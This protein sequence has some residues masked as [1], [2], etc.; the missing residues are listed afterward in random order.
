[1]ST[2]A[3]F[4][5]N[6][7]STFIEDTAVK[8]SAQKDFGTYLAKDAVREMGVGWD[9][10]NTFDAWDGQGLESETS[11]R[12]PKTTREMIAGVAERG[13]KTIRIPVTWHNHIIDNNYTIDPA[14]INRVKEVVDWALDS[15]L[16]VILN[17]HH[18]C[19]DKNE[20]ITYGQGYYP[21]D[22]NYEESARFVKNMWAQIAL[23][24]NGGY[25]HHLIFE[26]L[27]EPRLRGTPYEWN[28]NS[29]QPI[30]RQAADNTNKL[31]QLALDT[32]RA[33][34]GNNEKRFVMCPSLYA[35]VDTAVKSDFIMP[36]DTSEGRLILSTH[37]YSP[38]DFAMQSPGAEKFTG[39]HARY[40]ERM[41]DSLNANFVSRG[42]PVIMGE[43]GAVNKNNTEERIKWAKTYLNYA[44]K[45]NIPCCL[46]DNGDWK[47][48]GKTSPKRYEEKFGFYNRTENTW[49]F[50]ELMDAMIE[51]TE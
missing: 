16:Y 27:N 21:T 7:E 13:F 2:V 8:D 38:Y 28:H 32:I 29:A 24:F 26:T 22:E 40:L 34:G 19:H 33:S 11:W 4:A 35:S 6:I 49:Y 9:L 46:W 36:T 18:D 25:D 42:I 20:K 39:E 41:F 50:P 17:C 15:G 44:G 3:V 14:W 48:R 45:Y 1:M 12:Q 43:F 30:C 31:N 23:A 5:Q 10:G 37:A 51:A 47:V